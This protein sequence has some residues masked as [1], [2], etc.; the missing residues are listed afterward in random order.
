MYFTFKE[1]LIQQNNYKKNKKTILQFN[2]FEFGQKSK[3]IHCG[4]CVTTKAEANMLVL[5]QP[6]NY[7]LPNIFTEFSLRPSL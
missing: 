3:R 5:V 7:T 2:A 4:D 6:Q 1:A